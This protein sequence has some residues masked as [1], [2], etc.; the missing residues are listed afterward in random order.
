MFPARKNLDSILDIR[1]AEPGRDQLDP[2]PF[3][4]KTPIPIVKNNRIKLLKHLK[5]PKKIITIVY[6]KFHFQLII[7]LKGYFLFNIMTLCIIPLVNKYRRK[8]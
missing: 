6:F 4:K 3:L 5:T 1:V 2:D 8:K 7:C